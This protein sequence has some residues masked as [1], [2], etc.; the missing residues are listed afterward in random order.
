MSVFLPIRKEKWGYSQRFF[1]A[2]LDY[3]EEEIIELDSP[4][5]VLCSSG[6]LVLN[7]LIIGDQNAGKSSFLH[8]FTDSNNEN[9]LFLQSQIPFM[10]SSFLNV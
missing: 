7:V 10:S 6:T 9:F 1:Y 5:S 3:C 4:F 2:N 8:C